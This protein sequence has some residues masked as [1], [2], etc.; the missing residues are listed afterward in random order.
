MIHLERLN[1]AR[2][3]RWSPT[4]APRTH[5]QFAKT[6]RFPD[7][8]R[9][10]DLW[11]PAS[12]PAQHALV[13]VLDDPRWTEVVEV[14]PN[15]RGKTL[16]GVLLP[17]LRSLTDLS[18]NVIYSMPTLDKLDQQWQGRLR[19]SIGAAG[20]NA[21][22]PIK[23]PGSQGGKPGVIRFSDPHDST[24][25]AMLY[26]QGAGG[27]GKE[28]ALAS[29]TAPLVIAD[30]ADDFGSEGHLSLLRRRTRSFGRRFRV[31]I[32]STINN[33]DGRPGHP[34][35]ERHQRG[36]RSR[37]WYACPFCHAYQ[38]LEWERIKYDDVEARYCCAHCPALWTETDRQRA[39][40]NW[41]L[42]HHGQAVD[43]AGHVTGDAPTT[44]MLS[45]ITWDLDYRR[46]NMQEVVDEYRQCRKSIDE[47]GDHS[48]MRQFFFKV[49]VRDYDGD[50]VEA[51]DELTWQNL[52]AR[53]SN[54]PWGPSLHLTDRGASDSG[55]TYSRHRCEPPA[56]AAFAAAGIDVQHNRL[57][58]VLI[59]AS[60]T[61]TTWDVA[62]GYDF[63]RADQAPWN[64][65]E[66]HALLDRVSRVITEYSTPIPVAIAGVD[67]GDSADEIMPWLR[68]HRPI[69]LPVKGGGA[70]MK[71][72]PGDLDGVVHVRDGLYMIRTDHTRE[73]VHAAL[74]RPNGD[75]GAAI[76]PNGLG[77][78]PSD[79]AYLRHLCAEQLIVDP[80]TSK[81]KVRPGP[82]RWDWL[83]ARR[84]AHALMLYRLRRLTTTRPTPRAFG[85]VGKALA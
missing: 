60:L 3:E 10:G 82:G 74:R 31:I 25:S 71:A 61:G 55:H 22:L 36:T 1:R 47:R 35:L 17:L 34:V 27:G 45:R 5:Y 85:V 33:R 6:M 23:G 79:T 7:G 24:R 20:F 37:M 15:Q 48:A 9:V 52:L 13:Q 57:Y 41:R 39:L 49:L 18:Q 16:S 42:V 54:S 8:P 81:T 69:W 62:W 76:I 28:T 38:P 30:E 63:A 11:D 84:Y 32:V 29:N 51:S 83:D 80:K 73:L 66:L 21:W 72:E 44:D 64:T 26:F 58:W 78:N 12:E 4:A 50:R 56:D 19:P 70:A 77:N 59:A 65:A 53:S 14:G 67:V 2:A 68:G 43:A 75:A 40:D 46:A